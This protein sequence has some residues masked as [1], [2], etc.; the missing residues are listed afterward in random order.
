MNLTQ[1]IE[2]FVTLGNR[3][4]NLTESE[5]LA[6]AH[7]AHLYN[8]WFIP[9]NVLYALEA[10]ETQ[11]TEQTLNLW[12]QKYSFQQI[13]PQT[14]ALVMAG[15]IPLVGFHDLLCVLLSG[16][17]A[18]IKPSSQ[19]S[20]LMKWVAKLLVEINPLWQ[21]KISFTENTIADF[22]A[23]IAT[24]SNNSAR[25]FEQYFSKYPHI[26]RK[27]RTS[28]AV[29]T[30]NETDEEL[31]KL[32]EDVFRYYG[33]G[34]RNVSKVF[35]PQGYDFTKMLDNFQSWA[36]IIDNHRYQNNYD[37]NKSIYLVNSIPHLDTGFLL[38]TENPQ[39]V[40]PISVLY[41]DYYNNETELAETLLVLKENLQCIVATNYSQ[42]QP[43]GKAQ[44]PE[45]DDY[46]D[47][48]DTMKFLKSL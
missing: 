18:L 31:Q 44:Q 43:F 42:S 20:F 7:Q 47:G 32:S 24:G 9:E 8:N 6:A 45:I 15:N 16:H 5:K 3:L 19:D 22:Q 41:F 28:V 46:A 26:I 40:S 2:S 21:E 36:K 12:L 27:S 30:G 11:L 25:Y 34:C 38:I 33:L 23:V 48:I 37:Y 1:R 4:R 29:I 13:N 10:I 14:V 17:K 35:V 39:L